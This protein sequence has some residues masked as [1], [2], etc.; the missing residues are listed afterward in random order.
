[1]NVEDCI[2]ISTQQ[3]DEMNVTHAN[4]LNSSQLAQL[5]RLSNRERAIG[6]LLGFMDKAIAFGVS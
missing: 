2:G 4:H 5:P 3:D 6:I 1:L